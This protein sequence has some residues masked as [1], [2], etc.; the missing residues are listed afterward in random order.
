MIDQPDEMSYKIHTVATPRAGGMAVLTAVLAAGALTGFLWEPPILSIF[1]AGLIIFGLGAIDDARGMNAATKLLGQGLAAAVLIQSGVVVH[2]LRAPVADT[3]LTVL[4]V[5]G[6]TNA[7]NFI[8]SMDGEALGLA[9]LAAGFLML[10]M[11]GTGQDQPA[12]FAAAAM[13]ACGGLLYYNITPARLFLGDSGSQLLGF[14]LA[15]LGIVFTPATTVPQLSSWFVPIL[16]MIVPILDTTLVTLSRIR[17]RLPIYKGNR[18]HTYHRLVARGF[19]PQRAVFIIQLASA[20]AGCLAIISL[21]L[22]PLWANSIFFA[23]LA[24][25]L[26]AVIWLG[27][28]QAAYNLQ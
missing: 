11:T 25:G 10:A 18:D 4:W 16:I 22:P 6:V 26:A 21:A 2:V 17:L 12:L 8:D 23:A 14:W 20:V 28:K 24:L 5:V 27:Q 3:A 13:G 19:A 15:A 1:L 7:Y 9:G